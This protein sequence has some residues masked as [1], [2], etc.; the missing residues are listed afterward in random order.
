GVI[1]EAIAVEQGAHARCELEQNEARVLARDRRIQAAKAPQHRVYLAEQEA[2]GV[3]EMNRGLMDQKALHLL[4]VGLAV[5]VGVRALA[6]ARA[7][8]ERG[9]VRLAD[10]AGLDLAPDLL[11]PRLKPEVLVHDQEDARPLRH[12]DR[13]LGFGQR[14]AERLLADGR[15]P[16]RRG[17]ADQL[18]MG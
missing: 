2:E 4:E 10:G 5:E 18:Q 17:L 6:V 12:R 7:Q 16:A 15:Q 9:L 3:D 14:A 8:A 1:D 11:V 13:L